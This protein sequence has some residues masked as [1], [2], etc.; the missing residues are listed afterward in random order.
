MRRARTRAVLAAATLALLASL[1]TAAPAQAYIT[2]CSGHIRVASHTTAGGNLYEMFVHLCQDVGPQSGNSLAVNTRAHWHCRRN[3][4]VWDGCRV[5]AQLVVEFLS[6]A[7]WQDHSGTDFDITEPASGYFADSS[8]RV[9]FAAYFA[10]EV[11]VRAKAE[12]PDNMRFLLA[13]GTTV[14]KDVADAAGPDQEICTV[15]PC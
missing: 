11:H 13:D 8:T 4:A 9:S 14:L 1:F 5:N 12:D 15:D 3:G 6:S 10:D 7:G 2:G